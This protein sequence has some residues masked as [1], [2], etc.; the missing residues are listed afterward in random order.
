MHFLEKKIDKSKRLH[1]NKN[2]KKIRIHQ[3]GKSHGENQYFKV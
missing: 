1:Y 2:V 3:G